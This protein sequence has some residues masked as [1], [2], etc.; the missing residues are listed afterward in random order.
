MT[1][2]VRFSRRILFFGASFA[3]CAFAVRG[4]LA[5]QILGDRLIVPG[6]RVGSIRLG[7]A[8]DD[9]LGLLGQ[10]TSSYTNTGDYLKVDTYLQ[11]DSLNLRVDFTNSAA[12]IVRYIHVL[13]LSRGEFTFGTVV[14]NDF[15]PPSSDFQAVGGIGLGS[16]S[17]D[18]AKRFGSNF[19]HQSVIDMLYPALGIA[20]LVTVDHR[21]WQITVS[22]KH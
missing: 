1:L 13:A 20:F 18:V 15:D 19:A 6:D 4:A 5:A 12:P 8:W 21:V 2:S 7:M 3:L 9:V 16:S 11:Y 10:P 22:A 14:W 17:F